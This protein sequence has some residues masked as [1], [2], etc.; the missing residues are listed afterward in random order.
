MPSYSKSPGT[1]VATIRGEGAGVYS[2]HCPECQQM[3]HAQAVVDGFLE[4]SGWFFYGEKG[5]R[6]ATCVGELLDFQFIHFV[7]KMPNN[8][9]SHRLAWIDTK[10]ASDADSMI[11]KPPKHR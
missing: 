6:V 9:I 7:V 8:G 5:K 10:L 11:P 1:F 2:P 4:P 3:I